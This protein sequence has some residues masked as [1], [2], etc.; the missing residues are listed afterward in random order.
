MK[1]ENL[2]ITIDFEYDRGF[3][4]GTYTSHRFYMKNAIIS[5]E[6]KNILYDIYNDCRNSFDYL[7]V[8]ISFEYNN[9]KFRMS[10]CHYIDNIDVILTL[11]YYIIRDLK[12]NTTSFIN[13]CTVFIN[14]EYYEDEKLFIKLKEIWKE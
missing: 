3:S 5:E 6:E 2:K 4:N 7:A 1:I 12:N 13:I 14:N 9:Y 10:F 11:L 8:E